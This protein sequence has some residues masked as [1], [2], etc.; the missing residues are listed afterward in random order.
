MLKLCFLFYVFSRHNRL[1]RSVTSSVSDRRR[2]ATNHTR[3]TNPRAYKYYS[4]CRK[5]LFASA[6]RKHSFGS[7]VR[8]VNCLATYPS[9]RTIDL[10]LIDPQIAGKKSLDLMY[11]VNAKK[12][13]TTIYWRVNKFLN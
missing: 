2:L 13:W 1:K 5:M 7:L 8:V 4:S 12:R 6:K 11:N 9:V 10:V 3:H